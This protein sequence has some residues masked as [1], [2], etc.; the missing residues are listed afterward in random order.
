[1]EIVTT[2][3]KE[4]YDSKGDQRKEINEDE[5]DLEWNITST[6]EK[7]IDEVM[8]EDL[9]KT[10]GNLKSK[11]AAGPDGLE[12][13]AI[14]TLEVSLVKPLTKL[15]NQILHDGSVP[16][17][18]LISEI[19]LLYKKGNRFDINNYRPISLSSNMCKIFTKL[20]K[21]RLYGI[22]DSQQPHEQAGFRKG[23]STTDHI[24][25]VNQLLERARDYENCKINFL[26]ID[27]QKA[28]DSIHHNYVWRALINQGVPKVYINILSEF[29]KKSEAYIMLDKK[30]EK[31][32][33]KRGV[34]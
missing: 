20:L 14:K 10:I 28:F 6:R 9:A 1:M 2:F 23:F 21:E 12:N 11:K 5:E 8:E 18:W 26:F 7:E 32:P 34:K 24:L 15:F 3:F 17:Q 13:D 31:F 27:F 33:I 4:L 29:Y 16:N 30:G 19:I 22:L 25:A